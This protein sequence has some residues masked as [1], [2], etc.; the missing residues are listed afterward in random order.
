MKDRYLRIFRLSPKKKQF[1]LILRLDV[2][3]RIL[4]HFSQKTFSSLIEMIDI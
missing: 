2:Y 3:T 4:I 1:F